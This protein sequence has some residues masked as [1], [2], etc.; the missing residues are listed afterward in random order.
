MRLCCGFSRLWS[1][2]ASASGWFE[3]L[4]TEPWAVL[5]DQQER[6]CFASLLQHHT[7]LTHLLRLGLSSSRS[8]Q[9]IGRRVISILYSRWQYLSRHSNQHPVC[10]DLP[11]V[12]L[13][14]SSLV[15]RPSS[16]HFLVSILWPDWHVWL[17]GV[18]GCAQQFTY[19]VAVKQH[20]G[21]FLPKLHGPIMQ[22]WSPSH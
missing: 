21:K 20:K 1:R 11:S 15:F 19:L 13:T 16:C 6:Q 3:P 8:D 17:S 2:H 7:T 9:N 5:Q 12:C 4:R 14:M 10:P 22:S 18:A